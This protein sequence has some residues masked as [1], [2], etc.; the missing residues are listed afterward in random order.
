MLKYIFVV[1]FMFLCFSFV[2]WYAML[3]QTALFNK[4]LVCY[5][6]FKVKT[7]CYEIERDSLHD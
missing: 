2:L 6:F 1:F 7:Q 3:V 4:E 5:P